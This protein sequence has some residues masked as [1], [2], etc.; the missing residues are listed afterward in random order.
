MKT[1]AEYRL[2]A[3]ACR[4]LATKVSGPEDQQALETIARAWDRL[5]N[6]REAML[7]KQVDESS[8]VNQAAPG[9]D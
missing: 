2:H 6:E 3:E 1:V 5:A 9:R 4:K 8:G 7:L